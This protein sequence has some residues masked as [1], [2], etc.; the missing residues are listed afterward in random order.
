MTM[1]PEQFIAGVDIFG[2]SNLVTLFESIPPYW[3]PRF[4][5]MATR[6][7][8]PRTEE[9]LKLL[10]K[11]SPL[12]YANHIKHPLLI[13][14]GANDQRVKPGESEQIIAAM[15]GKHIPVTYAPSYRD[16][17]EITLCL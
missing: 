17:A 4:E 10:T 8:D 3:K 11:R 5:L 2:P 14:Q 9:G 6:V 16:A 13:G 12:T 15:M 7:G 1:T